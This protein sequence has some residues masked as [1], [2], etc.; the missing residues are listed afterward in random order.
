MAE[1]WMA[2]YRSRHTA[3]A[4]S[5][6]TPVTC[7]FS[8]EPVPIS[9]TPTWWMECFLSYG[10]GLV[11]VAESP[12]ASLL[13]VLILCWRPGA[14]QV[15]VLKRRAVC[16][17]GHAFCMMLYLLGKSQLHLAISSDCP[18]SLNVLMFLSNQSISNH[19]LC[20]G[21]RLLEASFPPHLPHW[22]K[23]KEKEKEKEE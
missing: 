18:C 8:L 2:F 16:W 4:S 14:S 6:L 22:F 15:L 5:Q 23:K 17:R 13:S 7:I 20:F 19:R 1:G 11:W 9:A 21:L 3:N 10:L 12:S